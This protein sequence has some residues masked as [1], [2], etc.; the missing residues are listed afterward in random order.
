MKSVRKPKDFSIE[1]IL[2]DGSMFLRNDQSNIWSSRF[3]I[4]KSCKIDLQGGKFE[5]NSETPFQKISTGGGNV[6]VNARSINFKSIKENPAPSLSANCESDAQNTHL[7]SNKSN[8]FNETVE[9]NAAEKNKA[10]FKI[11]DSNRHDEGEYSTRLPSVNLSNCFQVSKFDT[12]GPNFSEINDSEVTMR[13]GKEDTINSEC[14]KPKKFDVSCEER[15]K[16]H[17]NAKLNEQ[18]NSIADLKEDQSD[19]R[20]KIQKEPLK[21][22]R[23]GEFGN[24]FW[25]KYSNYNHSDS[26]E[27]KNKDSKINFC[28]KLKKI[29]N[30]CSS[31]DNNKTKATK[32]TTELEWLRCTRYRPPKIP[33]KST[34][35]KNRRKPSLHPR[36]P[37][38]TFQLDFLEQQF[39]HSAYLSKDDVSEISSA[40]NLPPNRVFS[41]FIQRLSLISFLTRLQRFRTFFSDIRREFIL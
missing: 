11:T 4:P 41:K 25:F 12:E 16:S 30:K 35:G 34:I 37:F 27:N 22:D 7:R 36:I 29:E 39:R 32:N 13:I 10:N 19:R 28:R 5:R 9:V 26:S 14:I 8:K 18:Q 33:R 6:A 40:L 38:S 20:N 21:Q 2:A 24:K 15:S 3:G 23:E 17:C 1:S 31:F